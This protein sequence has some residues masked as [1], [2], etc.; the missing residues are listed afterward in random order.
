MPVEHPVLHSTARSGRRWSPV[1]PHPSSRIDQCLPATFSD[2]KVRLAELK[3]IARWPDT[4]ELPVQQEA[5][6]RFAVRLGDLMK[7]VKRVVANLYV[8]QLP[9]GGQAIALQVRYD[10][11]ALNQ[12]GLLT[13][14]IPVE[15]NVFW[16]FQTAPNPQV[17][18][19]ILALAVPPN[20]AGGGKVATRRSH[21]GG[22]DA[23]NGCEN[24]VANGTKEPQPFCKQV[25]PPPSNGC[26]SQENADCF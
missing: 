2:A 21:W 14:T 9:Q 26:R 4:I 19:H 12:T 11:P 17:Q 10:D 18:P 22:D 3:P 8:G 25:R 20:S 16:L 6:G 23:A 7:E 13:E 15:A 5:D 1:A 24:R